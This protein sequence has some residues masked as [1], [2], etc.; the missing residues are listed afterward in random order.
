MSVPRADFDLA[1]LLDPVD[2]GLFHTEYWEKRPL[3]IKRDEPLYY[4]ELLSLDGA[5]EIIS[6]SD[7]RSG[8]IRIVRDGRESPLDSLM[9]S[10][11]TALGLEQLY[12]Q[13]RGGSTIVL[14]CIQERW[15]PLSKLCLT[16]STQLSAGAQ[17]NAYLTPRNARGLGTHYDTHD[18]LVL[19][20]HGS[21]HWRLFE[22]PELLPLPGQLYQS[23]KHGAAKLS[24]ELDLHPGDLLYVPRGV[25][26]EAVSKDSTSLHLT[27]GILP[28]TWAEVILAAVES[29]IERDYRFRESLPPGFATDEAVCEKTQTQAAELLN[30]LL[31]REISPQG[32]VADAVERAWQARK[33][34]LEGHLLDLE[35]EPA[36]SLSTVVRR[37]EIQWRLSAEGD[38]LRL[39]FH[40]KELRLPSY[41]ESDL[42]FI[43]TTHGSF[44]AA[45]LPGQLDEEGRLVLIRRLLHE[46]FLTL[47]PPD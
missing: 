21:K 13:Y 46:G 36:V 43:G 2:V 32:V 38:E 16:L 15:K 47:S 19:Q 39:R 24:Q 10:A 20:V 37:R 14:Q 29:V 34:I 5:D 42:R 1:R 35:A 22:S 4:R 12:A 45:S 9:S 18:V 44:T 26:H 8:Q 23:D 30:L 41:M 7:L 31:R 40:G 25:I 33:P 28:I 11:P 27:V 3:F 17:V 6:T